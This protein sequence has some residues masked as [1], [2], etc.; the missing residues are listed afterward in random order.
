MKNT[1]KVFGF[2]IAVVIISLFV[3]SN[4]VRA[5]QDPTP[6]HPVITIVK[7]LETSGANEG[8][9]KVTKTTVEVSYIDPAE[10]AARIHD[11]RT[12]KDT[13][14]DEYDKRINDLNATLIVPVEEE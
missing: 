6:G 3:T 13:V 9:I 11:L 14:A 5:T 12:E 10:V 4:I 8:K 7:H 1:L 2:G